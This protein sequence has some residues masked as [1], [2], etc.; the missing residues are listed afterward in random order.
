MKIVDIQ[1]K[2]V[3]FQ[4][5]KVFKIAF[6]T[7]SDRSNRIY[8]KII[9]DSGIYGLGEAAPSPLVA[10]ETLDGVVAAV[11]YMKPVLIGMDPTDIASIH[12]AMDKHLLFN[13]AAKAAIDVA[14]YDIIGKHTGKPVH[15][16]L[17]A[18]TD[19]LQTDITIG[20]DTIEEMVR[21]C[22]ERVGEGFRILKI[23]CGIDPKKD[24][25]VLRQIRSAVGDQIDLRIDI[26]QGYDVETAL[27][28]LRAIEKCNISEAEQPVPYWDIHGMAEIK[29]HSPIP[30]MADESVHTPEQARIVCQHDAADILNIKFMKCG[31]IYKALQIS[32][33]A[34]EYGKTC[35]VGC[36]SESKLAIAAAAAVVV[37]KDNI[38]SADLDSFFSFT[39][40]EK[41]V[42][43]GFTVA[44]DMITLSNGAGYGFDEYSF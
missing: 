11:S 37:T 22:L 31:G 12:N 18:N 13:P 30:I 9:T 6:G 3:G 43:G 15:K 20:I 36:M 33:I 19:V 1:T 24:V 38:V 34:A 2:L 32:D 26:N 28:V 14:C 5:R 41:G 8:V 25:E 42:T 27:H 10:G 40:P 29:K 17:G 16:L 21:E 44:G 4:R 35:L 23:K 39:D 7:G